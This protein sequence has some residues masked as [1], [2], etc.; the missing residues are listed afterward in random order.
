MRRTGCGMRTLRPVSSMTSRKAGG[1]A[2]EGALALCAREAAAAQ[3]KMTRVAQATARR[4]DD[5]K[6]FKQFPTILSNISPK[7]EDSP[8]RRPGASG[9][10]LSREER[11]PLRQGRVAWLT[12]P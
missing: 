4:R 7:N 9:C 5:C 3:G 11:G 8:A 1:S 2:V 12:A 6:F 10:A